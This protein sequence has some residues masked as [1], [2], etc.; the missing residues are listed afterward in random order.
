MAVC[1]QIVAVVA[2][3]I[4][5]VLLLTFGLARRADGLAIGD[6]VGVAIDGGIR[7]LI[8]SNRFASSND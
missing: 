4:V 6:C 1:F 3:G 2:G 7:S 5:V 8:L